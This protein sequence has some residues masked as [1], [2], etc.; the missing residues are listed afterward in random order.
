MDTVQD[1]ALLARTNFAF[2]GVNYV[3]CECCM[4]NIFEAGAQESQYLLCFRYWTWAAAVLGDTMVSCS[5]Y[6]SIRGGYS[7]PIG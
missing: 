5:G 1:P 6:L 2:S 7:T 4:A 3:P